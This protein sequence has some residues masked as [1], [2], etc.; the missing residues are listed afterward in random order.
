ME[1]PRALS[2]PNQ[3][4]SQALR[5]ASCNSRTP[6]MGTPLPKRL[7]IKST[8]KM[9]GFCSVRLPACFAL[10]GT[11]LECCLSPKKGKRKKKGNHTAERKKE[12]T[13]ACTRMW[14]SG[15][16]WCTTEENYSVTWTYQKTLLVTWIENEQS[17]TQKGDQR[18]K[19]EAICSV[20]GLKRL[21]L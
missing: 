16:F 8:E 5:R 6:L 9:R 21:F 4:Q 2:W 1:K 20:M 11:V 12:N 15:K 18:L 7:R 10:K 13:L 19:W 14:A 17:L 3:R